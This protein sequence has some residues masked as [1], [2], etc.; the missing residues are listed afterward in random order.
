LAL[1]DDEP[2]TEADAAA[3]AEAKA[4]LARGGAGACRDHARFLGKAWVMIVYALQNRVPAMGIEEVLTTPRSPWQ[5]P[6][7]ERIVGSIRRECLDHVIIFNEA[8]LRRVLS[9]YFR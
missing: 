4:Q 1:T 3:I 7:V 8:H 9:C 2:F 5:S 6:Y